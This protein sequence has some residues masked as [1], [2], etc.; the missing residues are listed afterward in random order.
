VLDH[1]TGGLEVTHADD[2][3]IKDRHDFLVEIHQTGVS[4][5]FQM[6]LMVNDSLLSKAVLRVGHE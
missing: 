4:R 1:R 6:D 5:F 3:V 2:A